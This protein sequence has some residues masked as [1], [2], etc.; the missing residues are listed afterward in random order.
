MRGRIEIEARE[1]AQLAPWALRSGDTRGRLHPDPPHP[2]RTEFQRDRDRVLHSR[3]FRRLQ[4]KTQ[5]LPFGGADHVRNRLTHTL[6]VAQIARTVSRALGANEDLTEAIVLAHD[7]GHPPFG[8]AGERILHEL[9]AEHGGFEHNRQS[10]RIVDW[11]EERSSRYRGLN[12]THETRAGLLKHGDHFPRFAH[13]VELPASTPQLGVEAQIA[14]LADE[15][16]YHSHDLD[17]GL[18]SELLDW[19]ELERLDLF[20]EA[21]ECVVRVHE[22]DLRTRQ[23]RT[24]STVIDTLASDLIESSTKRLLESDVRTPEDVVSAPLPL[25]GFSDEIRQQKREVAA[26]L[27]EHFYRNPVV[28]RMVERAERILRGLWGA[29]LENPAQLPARVF[30]RGSRE[31]RERAIAD[32]VAG[33]TDRF[34]WQEYRKLFDPLGDP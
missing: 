2:Y 24:I 18:R 7:L 12:L 13:P 22:F 29:Y 11:L 23:A 1:Q 26:Y 31:P 17:D 30:E 5:V 6:E 16:A 3:A 8:H 32:Y 19:N 9:L 20:H 25:V 21:T 15:I 10:L 28:V 33:M 27:L 14:N 34:A 4:F